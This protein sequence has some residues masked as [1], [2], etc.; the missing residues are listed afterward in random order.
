MTAG[1]GAGC[2][3]G[4]RLGAAFLA[5]KSPSPAFSGHEVVRDGQRVLDSME[6]SCGVWFRAMSF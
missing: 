1:Q 4:G 2:E 5:A 3:V 6:C